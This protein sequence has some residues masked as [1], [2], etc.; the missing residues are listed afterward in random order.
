M[1]ITILTIGSRGDVQPYIALGCGLQQAG[2]AVRIGTHAVFRDFITAHGLDFAPVEGNPRAM[3]ETPEGRGWLDSGGNPF[4]FVSN[5]VKLTAPRLQQALEDSWRAAQGSDLIIYALFGNAGFHIAEKLGI[6]GIMAMLQPI[7]P[8]AAFQAMGAPDSMAVFERWGFANRISHKTTEQVLWLPFR[9]AVNRWRVQALGLKPLSL[10]GPF[11]Q[12]YAP[13]APPVLYGYSPAVIPRPADWPPNVHVTGYWF[14]DEPDGWRPPDALAAFLAREPRPIYVGFGSMVDA[15]PEGLLALVLEALARSG[16]RA[17][18]LGG[19]SDLD[20]AVLPETVLAVKDVPHSWLFA[21]VA[22]V[23]HHGGSGTTA[24]GLRAGVPGILVPYF[25]DQP[26]WGK[27]VERLGVGHSIPRKALTA[28][29]LAAAVAEAVHNRSLR[30]RATR[31]GASIQAE[32]GV[33]TAVAIV[34]RFLA[35]ERERA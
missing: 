31:L 5:F 3:L 20:A 24:A 33:A 4:Q 22:A 10:A 6:P 14:L 23:V 34:N 15:D 26:F 27:Q 21:R 8:T 2:H 1:K 30:E 12:L 16:Q 7:T 19:W 11:P 18:L 35:R 32:D 17:V 28:D 29:G 25:G 13:D 9:Q